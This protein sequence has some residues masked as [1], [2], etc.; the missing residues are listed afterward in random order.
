MKKEKKKFEAEN[1]RLFY[2]IQYDRIDKLETK[3]ENFCNYIITISSAIIIL[4]L[5]S[6]KE[7][8]LTLLSKNLLFL[9]L[10]TLNILVII[11]INKTRL[12]VNMHQAR[13]KEAC[14]RYA[15]EFNDIK[16][17]IE[18]P[19][20]N[21]DIFRRSR[22]YSYVHSLIILLAI[23]FILTENKLLCN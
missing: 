19:E 7:I 4:G 20:S 8:T 10:I 15:K 18:K 21:D 9:F 13:A 2:Q 11:F 16:E 3:R 1:F 14:D 12:W 23:L 6:S 5:N 17:L 22:I